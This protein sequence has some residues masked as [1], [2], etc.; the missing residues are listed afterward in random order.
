LSSMAAT[1]RNCSGKNAN[2]FRVFHWEALY[3]RRGVVR[4][5]PG[6]PHHRWARPR[7][8]PRP[9]G[10]EGALWPPSGSRLVL[11]LPPG[12]IGVSVFVLSNSE[13]ISGVAFL[14]HKNSR[15]TGNWH[16]GILS[17]G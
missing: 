6:G 8:R 14:K 11:V 16:C 7:P 5:G 13:N 17:I 4:S 1:L 15:K 9:P 2:C 10:G 12:K 3:R